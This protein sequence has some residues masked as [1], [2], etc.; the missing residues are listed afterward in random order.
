MK[1]KECFAIAADMERGAMVIDRLHC[2]N[3]AL[4]VVVVVRLFVSEVVF[5][6]PQRGDAER[7]V[8]GD[9]EPDIC[10]AC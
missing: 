3:C 10:I 1:R 2:L 7:P 5:L 9:S 6:N 8:N 4:C